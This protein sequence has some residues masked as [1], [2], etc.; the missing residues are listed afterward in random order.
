[1]APTPTTVIGDQFKPDGTP[2]T[3]VI[4][5]ILCRGTVSYDTDYQICGERIYITPDTAG[6][7][8]Q[9]LVD[10]EGMDADTFYRFDFPNSKTEYV[11]IDSGLGTVNYN[12]L[13]KISPIGQ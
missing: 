11:Q 1:M 10:T 3:D 4:S 2:C 6:H 9:D 7:W 13:T 8:E 5:A 12:S